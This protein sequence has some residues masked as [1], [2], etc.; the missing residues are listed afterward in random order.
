MSRR[1]ENIF[2]KLSAKTV[3]DH[4]YTVY[5]DKYYKTLILIML[6]DFLY[7]SRL[8]QKCDQFISLVLQLDDFITWWWSYWQVLHMFGTAHR[9]SLGRHLNSGWDGKCQACS[10][11]DSWFMNHDP[12]TKMH[13]KVNT[14]VCLHTHIFS[15]NSFSPLAQQCAYLSTPA[16]TSVPCSDLLKHFCHARLFKA[17]QNKMAFQH[18]S[19]QTKVWQVIIHRSSLKGIIS[20]INKN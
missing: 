14:T 12:F 1:T 8:C 6:S 18:Q 3:E 13:V 7:D 15:T 2:L 19:S 5:M 11:C 16:H 20:I 9:P 4:I 17:L 10:F